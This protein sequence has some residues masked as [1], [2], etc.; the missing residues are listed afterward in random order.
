[1]SKKVIGILFIIGSCLYAPGIA[2]IIWGYVGLILMNLQHV[3]PAARSFNGVGTFVGFLFGGI[4]LVSIGSLAVLA[5][6]T[7]ALIKLA[8]A[9]EWIWFVLMITFGWVVLLVYLV[10]GP[11]PK[12]VSQAVSYPYSY[13]VPGQPGPSYLPQMPLPVVQP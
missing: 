12:P 5:A 4:A 11:K 7:V 10:V 6:R 8:E 1:V 9:Q 3:S 2:M 13:P